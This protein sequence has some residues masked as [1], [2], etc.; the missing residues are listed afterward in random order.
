MN[1][2]RSG[3]RPARSRRAAGRAPDGLNTTR[4]P[5]DAAE[6]GPS[7]WLFPLRTVDN[8]GRWI[9]V[10]VR[11]PRHRLPRVALGAYVAV[12]LALAAIVTS[13]FLFD[14]A[15]SDWA[16]DLPASVTGPADQITNLGRSGY[17][18][19]PLGFLVIGLAA[20]MRPSLPR[21]TQGVVAALAARFG[22]LFLAIG[23]PSLFDTIAKR[24]I[25][26]ARPYVGP[27]DDPFAY[28]P[29][30]WRPEYASM[31]SGHATTAAAAAIA[32]GAIW[33]RARPV[34]WLYAVI[35]FASRVVVHVHHPSDVVAGGFVGV[36][37]ALMVRRWFAARG[38]VFGAGDLR[39]FAGPSR[40]RLK[41]A[42]RSLVGWP[43]KP[44]R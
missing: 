42:A 22:F 20:V 21:M 13:M 6:S 36:I 7:A 14:V 39:A 25:G 1:Q 26:R 18:L 40:R 31:P 9:A 2:S 10:L 43:P 17:F 12:A 35:I 15:V 24:L 19:Y 4:Q 44:R 34:M 28:K 38:L 29:F 3:G 32:I 16:R 8:L 23:T 37:G 41:A 30:I 27:V 11:R 33:P 5:G